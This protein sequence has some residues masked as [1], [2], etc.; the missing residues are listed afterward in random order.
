[1]SGLRS[2]ITTLR[3]LGDVAYEVVAVRDEIEG[4]QYVGPRVLAFG[5]LLAVSGGHGTPGVGEVK[6][7]RSWAW[8]IG[9]SALVSSGRGAVKVCDRCLECVQVSAQRLRVPASRI[10]RPKEN[11]ARPRASSGRC[12]TS[13]L[14][15]G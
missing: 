3:S 14:N 5:P 8:D 4:G 10:L 1:M 9:R 15:A 13:V 11:P 12:A 2:G 7:A 6:R